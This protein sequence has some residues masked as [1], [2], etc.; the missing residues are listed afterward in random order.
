[1]QK[2]FKDKTA[3][4]R[5]NYSGRTRWSL[6]CPVKCCSF[7]SPDIGKHL[8]VKHRWEKEAVKLQTTYFH[9]IFNYLT[10]V[11]TYNQSKP[12]ICFRCKF[13]VEHID[14]HIA[15]KH[16]SRGTEDYYGIMR[17]FKD[18]SNQILFGR[19]SFEQSCVH[20]LS[21]K[22]AEIKNYKQA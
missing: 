22:M 3:V 2:V 5:V 9:N 18:K 21:S 7:S 8:L 4:K 6:P 13:I 14:S 1:M 10:R 15:L 20:D 19:E 16:H 17:E 11:N 12:C